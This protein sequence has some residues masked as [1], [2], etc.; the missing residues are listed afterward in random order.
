M[1]EKC[2]WCAW[3]LLLSYNN[4]LSVDKKIWKKK[5][6]GVTISLR[7]GP[8]HTPSPLTEKHK[9]TDIHTNIHKK[10][11]N[12]SFFHFST[13]S[14]R[15]NG[16]TNGQTDKASYRVVCPQPKRNEPLTR[17]TTLTND[18]LVSWWLPRYI[19]TSVISNNVQSNSMLTD[20]DFFS[21]LH[22]TL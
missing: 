15:T 14:S 1:G 20:F 6:T 11:L 8:I 2:A 19:W 13:R 10:D 18:P 3:H 7:T 16:L 5:V 17:L 22:A 12:R 21:R 4:D 9:H